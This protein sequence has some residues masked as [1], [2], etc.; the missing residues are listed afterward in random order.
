[1]QPITEKL[2]KRF[3]VLLLRDTSDHPRVIKRMNILKRLYAQRGLVC[4]NIPLS[5]VTR[6][7]RMFSSLLL[8][9]WTAYY[10]AEQYGLESEQ[11][12]MVEQFK[13]LMVR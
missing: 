9:D 6:L 8:A 2:S 4:E 3:A 13:K 1:V 5:G 11:V 12:P 7:Q 10:T